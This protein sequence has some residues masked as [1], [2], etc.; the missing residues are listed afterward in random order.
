MILSLI[1]SYAKDEKG[2]LVIGCGNT[3]PWSSHADLLRFREYTRGHPVIMG[4]K[5]HEAIGRV[6]PGRKNIVVTSRNL[7]IPGVTIVHSAEEALSECKGANEAFIIGGQSLYEWALDKV[8]R[9]YIT[10]VD[11]RVSGDAFF[12]NYKER[13]FKPI[14][15]EKVPGEK[16]T[17]LQRFDRRTTAHK[18]IEEDGEAAD[19]STSEMD[20]WG[21]NFLFYEG[22]NL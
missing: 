13:H 6:L 8:E 11:T 12:P 10:E 14:H 5:T 17:I 22:Y 4:R 3:S 1:A 19:I 9:M 2:Q 15:L 21:D 16:F 7:Q 20:E 18:E